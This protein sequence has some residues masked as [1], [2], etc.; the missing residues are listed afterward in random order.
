[1]TVEH[2][3][4]I[5]TLRESHDHLSNVVGGLSATRVAG[6]S[7]C[8]EWSTAQVLSHLGSGAEIGL[9][10]LEAARRGEPSPRE[11]YQDIWDIWNAKSPAAMAADALV[12]DERHVAAL[13]ALNDAA[14]DD[15]QLEM[16]GRQLDAS[17][18]VA[19]RL[20]EHAVHTWDVEVVDD[21][22]VEVQ[23]VPS[24]LLV[25]RLA[26]RINRAA[27][28]PKPQAAPVRIAV[29][30][31]VIDE[32]H[33]LSIT[34]DEVGFDDDASGDGRLSIGAG[35]LLRLVSGRLDPDHTPPS[36][37][38]SGPVSLDDLRKLFPGR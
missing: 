34:D 29:H 23:S 24:E 32:G 3:Q 4:W 27:S 2:R 1:M 9:V 19:M 25:G 8:S 37:E 38:M 33:G 16:M 30:V 13:E 36:V 15:L 28:G 26:D 10:N 31:N 35:A 12:A 17:A 20:F 6:P 11:R 22:S 18:I 5:A 14:L 21:P 7:Y